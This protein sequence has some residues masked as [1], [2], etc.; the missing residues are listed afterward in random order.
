MMSYDQRMEVYI[1]QMKKN[2]SQEI[3]KNN[4]K[5]KWKDARDKDG[6]Y[7]YVYDVSRE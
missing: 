1:N 4:N 7:G 3:K 6:K 2:K 5:N